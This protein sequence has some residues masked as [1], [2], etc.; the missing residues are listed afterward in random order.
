ML[1]SSGLLYIFTHFALRNA[2]T[3]RVVIISEVEWKV[4]EGIEK[5]RIIRKD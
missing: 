3:Y 1:L 4:N 5:I 2:S